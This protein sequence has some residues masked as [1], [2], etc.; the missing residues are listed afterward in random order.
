ML[1]GSANCFA[2]Q[3]FNSRLIPTPQ[4]VT[5]GAGYC[6][7]KSSDWVENHEGQVASKGI[8]K[9]IKE[10][11]TIVYFEKV[12][13]IANAENQDQAYQL[14]ITPHAIYIRYVS[15]QKDGGIYTARQNLEKLCRL[16]G[17]SIPCMT[18][19]DWPAY[20][21]RGFMDDISRGPIPSV[22]F[23]QT[24]YQTLVRDLNMNYGNYYTEHALYNPDYPDIVPPDFNADWTHNNAWIRMA[25]LQ[26]FAHFEKTLRIPF[27]QNIMDTRTNVNPGTEATYTFLKNQIT[28]TLKSYDPWTPFFNINCDET[29]ALGSGHA[30][31]Y[32]DAIGADKAYCQHIN[33]VYDLIRECAG[34]LGLEETPKVL[35]WGDIVGKNPEMLKLLPKEMQYIIWSYVAKESYADM[36]APFKDIHES[37]GNDFWVAPGVSHWSSIPQVGNYIQNI[38]YLARDGHQ[39]G[40]IG[41]MN[42]AWDDSGESLFGDCWH[43]MAW[44]AEMAWNPIKSTDPIAAKAELETREKQFNENYA[45]MAGI[46]VADIYA[47]G[48]LANNPDVGDWFNTGSLMHPLLDFYPS[49]VDTA[50]E[51]RCQRVIDKMNQLRTQINTNL[52]HFIYGI[53]RIATVAA[54]SQLRI[55]FYKTL[56]NPTADNIA[57]SN[58]LAEAYF[59][60]LHAL[61]NEYL[62]LWDAECTTYSREIICDRYDR[63]GFEVLEASRKVIISTTDGSAGKGQTTVTLKTLYNDRPI[64]YTLDGRKPTEGSTLYTGPFDIDRSC[65]VK[66]V[67]YDE[68]GEPV[69][70]EQYLLCH[71]GMGHLEKLNS[72]YSTYN[73]TYSAG[74]D[75]ALADGTLGD[76]RSYSDG[77]WQGYWGEDIDAIYHFGKKTKIDNISLRF[78]QNTFDWILAPK[79]MELYTSNDG[80]HWT[81]AQKVNCEPEFRQG[82]NI[83]HTEGFHHLDIETVYLRVVVRNPGLLPE[84]H[85]ARGQ[86]SYLFCDEIVI[87]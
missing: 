78:L 11:R 70:S 35:M 59:R 67:C 72:H 20:K 37:Q 58:S 79:Q 22:Q 46:D 24:Q 6:V 29:E 34:E 5:R 27:Y 49:N 77:H 36:I 69:Y 14:E 81:L 39:A 4:M 84:W 17:D 80:R 83:V 19:T 61:K 65:L 74:G 26:C 71:K 64:Y 8:K 2:Q 33:R 3:P 85:P 57:R 23:R 7:A 68:W 73:E 87:E 31:R 82:G 28:N 55:Q 66:A 25:N 21:Y 43:A 18:I 47:V 53:N 62:R 75:N 56:Q 44:G 10:G 13:S 40:A 51:S 15:D 16:W 9:A 76:D 50:T 1:V 86:R 32:V 52:P 38:A 12:D 60:Q 48:D 63:L 41:L 42:T 54:K 45:R 30:R